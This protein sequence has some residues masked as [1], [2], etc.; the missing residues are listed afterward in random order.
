MRTILVAIDGSDASTHALDFA[1]RQAAAVSGTQLHVL[2]VRPALRVYGE[3]EVYAGEDRMRELA[4]EEAATV[5]DQARQRLGEAAAGVE[6]EQLEGDPGEIIV[7]RAREL[8]CESIVMGTHGRGRLAS[9]VMGS[10][11]HRVVHRSTVPVTLTR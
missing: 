4:S 7:K 9:A 2:Y 8:E 3:I 11:A 1:A 10:V 6:F 5:L